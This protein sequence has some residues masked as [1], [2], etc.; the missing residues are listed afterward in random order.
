MDFFLRLAGVDVDSLVD[1]FVFDVLC[2]FLVVVLV[3]LG[4]DVVGVV[5]F[6]GLVDVVLLEGTP[7]SL[8][9][10]VA[11]CPIG[12]CVS[13]KEFVCSPFDNFRC[14]RSLKKEAMSVLFFTRTGV[15]ACGLT[16]SKIFDIIKLYPLSKVS[17]K[18]R[19]E[20]TMHG[21]DWYWEQQHCWFTSDSVIGCERCLWLD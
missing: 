14:R 5:F 1:L 19:P 4:E 21:V 2:A 6:D 15:N 11:L 20:C 9:C 16:E 13:F 12:F 8:F 17:N 18:S 10:V 7:R 3:F